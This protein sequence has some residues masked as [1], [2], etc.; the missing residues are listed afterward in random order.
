MKIT[1]SL[2]IC[3][4][5]FSVSHSQSNSCETGRYAQDIFE[6]FT[7]TTVPFG[8]NTDAL[9]Q[10]K[11]LSMDIYTPNNDTLAERPLMIVAHGGTF[12]T[13]TRKD[14]GLFC[15]NFVTK[16]FVCATIDYRLW[17]IL[18]LGFPDSTGLTE[19]A[20]GAISDMKAA[21]RF[22]RQSYTEGNPFGIDTN[23]IIVGGGSAGAITALHAGLLNPNDNIPKNL[24]DEINAQ[25]GF[26]GNSGDSINM[27]FSSKVHAVLNL[28]GA[29]FD[30][31]FISSDDVPIF[32]I[33]G[34]ADEVVPFEFGKA[35]GLVS[36]MGSK[37]VHQRALNVGL[38]ST[39]TEVQEGGH[40]NIYFEEKFAED[41]DAYNALVS[42]YWANQLCENTTKIKS[43]DLDEVITIF[44]N[45]ATS[46]FKIV[47]DKSEINSL[48][49]FA[50]N[51]Q[52]VDFTFDLNNKEAT[53]TTLGL[54]GIYLVKIQTDNGVVMRK[55]ILN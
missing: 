10:V 13:G 53:V 34:N 55:V 6:E 44:P 37:L 5:T 15:E 36:M 42:S 4:L 23:L 41:L 32:S 14:M 31:I 2:L 24:M 48:D 27:T 30:T 25:G 20:V 51:G 26:E 50:L 38:V 28:S 45:P 17:P 22:F 33:Q 54:E 46:T 35:A 12:I 1:I 19:T 7:I 52:R 3:L 40:A 47:G 29:I 9:Q 11:N 49:L 16:G 39:L 18:F 8:S 43:I 21:I